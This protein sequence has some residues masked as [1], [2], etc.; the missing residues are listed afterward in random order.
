MKEPVPKVSEEDL[1][2]LDPNSVDAD[3]IRSILHWYKL[4]G[5]GWIDYRP[6]REIENGY[7]NKMRSARKRPKSRSKARSKPWRPGLKPISKP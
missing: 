2:D 3:C 6:F 7:L 1:D 5:K 4:F